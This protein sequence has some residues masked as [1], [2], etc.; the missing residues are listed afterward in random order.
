M[1]TR[2]NFA[3]HTNRE[4]LELAVGKATRGSRLIAK[5]ARDLHRTM[6]R[7]FP[8]HEPTVVVV[9]DPLMFGVFNDPN[10][11]RNDDGAPVPCNIPCTWST[12]RSLLN[13][14]ASALAVTIEPRKF[15]TPVTHPKRPRQPWIGAMLENNHRLG[16]YYPLAKRLSRVD[17]LMTFELDAHVYLPF[18]INKHLGV[19][20]WHARSVASVLRGKRADAAIAAFISNCERQ[21]EVPR[22]GVLSAL[23]QEGIPV[24]QYGTCEHNINGRRQDPGGL[25]RSLPRIA[26]KL[27]HVAP[28]RIAVAMENSMA[29]DYVTEKVYQV[30]EAGAVPLFIG[31][32][33][34]RDLLP[35]EPP[36]K[37]I[38]DVTDYLT[39]D[40]SDV[41]T[42]RLAA[43]LKYLARNDSAYAEYHRWRE[44]PPP[45]RWLELL[46]IRRHDP[47]CR[48]CHC[49]HGRLGCAQ[50]ADGKHQRQP[51]LG[52]RWQAPTATATTT[53]PGRQ[54]HLHG[55][56]HPPVPALS[57]ASRGADYR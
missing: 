11:A 53:T 41:D 17:I 16:Q 19:A 45:Q 7:Q 25:R 28:Y 21:R 34:V 57:G 37:C 42:R 32:P 27:E 23:G 35:C 44:H 30:F 46:E 31:A 49:V 5:I 3:S 43:H 47:R 39:P 12:E 15:S 6:E 33:N 18:Y 24:H 29:L 56:A 40:G 1:T 2:V 38:V 4:I 26:H 13:T 55:T 9:W 14:T 54:A 52:R 22:L 8:N 50:A 20:A 10:D 36:D 48:A 51:H